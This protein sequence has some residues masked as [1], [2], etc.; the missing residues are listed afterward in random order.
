MKTCTMDFYTRPWSNAS[1]SSLKSICEA[2]Q[3]RHLGLQVKQNVRILAFD[4]IFQRDF[5]YRGKI[6][7]DL[8]FLKESRFEDDL[9]L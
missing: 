8:K 2:L 6:S 3:K 1:K 9:L 4:Y 5:G 7:K